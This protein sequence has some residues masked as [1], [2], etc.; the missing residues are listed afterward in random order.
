M[1]TVPAT[2][3]KIFNFFNFKKIYYLKRMKRF[4]FI[5]YFSSHSAGHLA[6]AD[7]IL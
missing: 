7:T 2:V 5:K 4:Q 6:P 1:E 3:L